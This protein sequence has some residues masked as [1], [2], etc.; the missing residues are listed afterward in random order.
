MAHSK[1]TETRSVSMDDLKEGVTAKAG[2]PLILLVGGAPGSDVPWT[3]D[4]GGGDEGTGSPGDPTGDRP[5]DPTGENQGTADEGSHE[6]GTAAPADSKGPGQLS[7]QFVNPAGKPQPHVEAELTLPDGSKRAGKSDEEGYFAVQELPAEGSCALNVP[8]LD[9]MPPSAAAAAEGHVKYAPAMPLMVGSRTIVELPAMIR[10]G[11]LTGLHFET[12]KTFLR[13]SAMA[14]IRMLGTLY[15][16]YANLAVLVSGHTDTQGAADYNRGLSEERAQ[17][18]A[19]FLQDD[20]DSWLGKY[21]PQPHSK[22]WGVREDQYMLATLPQGGTPFYAGKIDGQAGPG[23]ADAY[24]KFQASKGLAQSGKG[25]DDTRRALITDYMALEGTS[26]PKTAKVATHGCGLTHLAEP[27]GPGVAS[28]TNRRVEI[29][30]F[31]D[32]ATPPPQTPCPAGGCP[33]YPQWVSQSVVT[34]DLD[35]PPGKLTVTVS[36][37]KGPL[38]GA[39]VHVAGPIALDLTTTQ[40]TASFDNL[41]PGHYT[42]IAEKADF[43]AADAQVDIAPGAT[44]A[45][46]LTVAPVKKQ[47]VITRFDAASATAKDAKAF[48]TANPNSKLAKDRV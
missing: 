28:E 34:V 25:D 4:E 3:E 27:T 6:E 29:F 30:L 37:D 19:Q 18:I 22:A 26:T 35:Q 11:K 9:A 33:E 45:V 23:T 42:V 14:G 2:H 17:S 46:A 41:V 10:R 5:P 15:Q 47:M 7:V 48:G 24:K 39:N 36:D 21:K 40:G 8:D 44:G 38:D 32:D 1:K 12:D 13:P 20:V 31:E 43:T 16:S